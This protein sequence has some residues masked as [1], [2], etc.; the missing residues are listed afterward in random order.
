MEMFS[1]NNIY[2][3]VL[4]GLFWFAPIMTFALYKDAGN[5]CATG[6]RSTT[7]ETFPLDF[8]GPQMRSIPKTSSEIR[9][10]ASLPSYQ[11]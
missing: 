1:L 7:P 9:S 5:D 8:E 11:R 10:T 4:E 2:F 6:G 3:S